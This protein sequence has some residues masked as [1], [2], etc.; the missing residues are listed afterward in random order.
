[1]VIF[2]SYVSLPE[3][4][5][6]YGKCVVFSKAHINPYPSWVLQLHEFLWVHSQLLN[7]T[8]SYV[9]LK[10]TQARCWMIESHPHNIETPPITWTFHLQ[11]WC[12]WWFLYGSLPFSSPNF[13]KSPEFFSEV[14]ILEN[15]RM[16]QNPGTVP[17]TPKNSWDL[18]MFIPLKMV[19]IGIDPYPSMAIG[20]IYGLWPPRHWDPDRLEL[21]PGPWG[22]PWAPALSRHRDLE[23]DWELWWFMNVSWWFLILVTSYNILW[24]LI[25]YHYI[26]DGCC[27]G[28]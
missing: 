20:P 18:W 16:G 1:M 13:S 24:H 6:I 19:S 9:H 23:T 27:R 4:I 11:P 26:V 25:T 7:V 17:W 21:H 2:H 22:D 10:I 5:Q 3:G 15:L 28:F 12:L 8:V 14:F